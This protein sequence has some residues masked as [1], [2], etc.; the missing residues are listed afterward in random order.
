[1]TGDVHIHAHVVFDVVGVQ[2]QLRA[3]HEIQPRTD[4]AIL[5]CKERIIEF[6][7]HRRFNAHVWDV[8][9]CRFDI[10]DHAI[11]AVRRAQIEAQLVQPRFAQCA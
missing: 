3:V 9:L 4:D 8:F 6:R 5:L 1:M 11:R 7:G 2:M 10:F